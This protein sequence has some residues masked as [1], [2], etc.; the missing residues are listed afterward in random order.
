MLI[1]INIS[2]L[3]EHGVIHCAITSF[4]PLTNSVPHKPHLGARTN[5]A[6]R[7]FSEP[8]FVWGMSFPKLPQQFSKWFSFTFSC[9]TRGGNI[10]LPPPQN[11]IS[12][13]GNVSF[14][15]KNSGWGNKKRKASTFYTWHREEDFISILKALV[16]KCY[17][18][19]NWET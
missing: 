8:H 11:S 3:N 12:D 18:K 19:G 7:H 6:L 14:Q 1:L 13:P 16:K 17:P 5:F 15:V 2:D 4:F 9:T 10:I